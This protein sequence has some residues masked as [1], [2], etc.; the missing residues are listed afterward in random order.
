MAKGQDRKKEVKKP[1]KAKLP[2][3][4]H[5]NGNDRVVGYTGYLVLFV[6]PKVAQLPIY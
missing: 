1:K 6:K 4:Q 5:Q 3:A 2:K